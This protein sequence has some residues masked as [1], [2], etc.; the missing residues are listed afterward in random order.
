MLRGFVAVGRRMSI[1]L[2]ADDMCIT[3][4][5]MSRQVRTLEEAFGVKLLQRGHRC[6]AFTE[7]GQR[8]FDVGNDVMLQLQELVDSMSAPTR[9][10]VTV[11]AS[12]GTAGLWLLPRLAGFQ[13]KHPEIDVRI[14]AE[15]RLVDLSLDGVDLAIRY[16]PEEGAPADSEQLFMETIAP[17]ASPALKLT[18]P[19][20]AQ[21]LSDLVLIEFD[22]P[23][24]RHPWLR[25]S[26]WLAARGLSPKDA[27][28]VLLFNQYDQLIQAA[29]AGQGV[30]LGR[31]ELLST[32]LASGQLARVDEGRTPVTSGHGYWL[33]HGRF[34]AR[35]EVEA[36]VSWLRGCAA[37]N[38]E[39]AD[40]L[41]APG[42]G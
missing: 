30:A 28:G 32:A 14:T 17:V 9:R 16:C 31:L 42:A 5:A 22:E 21:R 23:R 33:V 29:A 25:W 36:V 10:P 26:D 2:G 13:A 24:H 12:S 6:I 19:L 1:T 35:E 11:S 39:S 18:G 8:L 37:E 15:N 38:V 4:S 3:Q 40:S 7:A 34:P 20:T 41:G 27:R